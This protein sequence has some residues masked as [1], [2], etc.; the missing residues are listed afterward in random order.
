VSSDN[1]VCC[2]Y[3]PVDLKPVEIQFSAD[4]A[5]LKNSGVELVNPHF[6]LFAIAYF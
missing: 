2:I 6:A 1:P 3:P 5:T 4:I